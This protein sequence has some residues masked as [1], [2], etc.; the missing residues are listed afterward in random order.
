MAFETAWSGGGDRMIYA[1]TDPPSIRSVALAVGA[2]AISDVS[3]ASAFDTSSRVR[4]PRLGEIVVWQNTAGYFLA[5]KIEGLRVR[6][7]NG[8]TDEVR[9]SYVIQ[10]NRTASFQSPAARLVS[11]CRLGSELQWEEAARA[12]ELET[13]AVMRSIGCSDTEVF[14]VEHPSREIHLTS[15]RWHHVNAAMSRLDHQIEQVLTSAQAR[16]Q[17]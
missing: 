6:G 13:L 14:K 7:K 10:T 5:T 9:F 4:A 17:Q 11:Q 1:Y 16:T 15:H 3:D 8:V 2:S 12:W